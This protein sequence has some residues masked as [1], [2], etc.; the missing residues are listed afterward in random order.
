MYIYWIAIL[1]ALASC[2]LVLGRI[3]SINIRHR[4][5][6]YA[7][8]F[9]CG[10]TLDYF[11]IPEYWTPQTLFNLPVGIEGYVFTLLI[12]L[13]SMSI[14]VL[15]TNTSLEK[16]T[17]FIIF[18]KFA[19]LIPVILII[20]IPAF[21]FVKL[22]LAMLAAGLILHVAYRTNP[23]TVIKHLFIFVFIY[24]AAINLWLA[25]VPNGINWFNFANLSGILVIK[26]PLEEIIFAGCFAILT[27]GIMSAL[28]KH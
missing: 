27:S 17:L 24:F 1:I 10:V 18:Q 15:L 28:C 25:L 2:L 3:R 14:W 4:L 16:P 20:L 5:F 6:S 7:L 12:A 26:A 8:I 9:S 19:I 22:Y 11:L 23:N 13:V 21:N